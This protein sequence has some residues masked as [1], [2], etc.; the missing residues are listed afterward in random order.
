LTSDSYARDG[1]N[2]GGG[3]AKDGWTRSISPGFAVVLVLSFVTTALL[4]IFV[5]VYFAG[6]SA[7]IAS[8]YTIVASPANRA[9][10]AE[11]DGY[12]HNRRRDLAA[13]SSDLTREV[14]TVGSFD[15]QLATV[16][17][18]SAAATAAGALTQADQKLA[19]LIGL[20][21]RAPSL[22]KM[23]SFDPRVEAAATVVKTQARLVRQALGL[24]P[25]SGPLF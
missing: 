11:V 10:T 4:L 18:P 9:L 5:L 20:Q 24:P 22:R 2:T 25:S 21:T 8:D 1:R 3:Y 23:R 17:F 13:A 12:I 6:S 7:R 16:S 19:K 14:G 15:E